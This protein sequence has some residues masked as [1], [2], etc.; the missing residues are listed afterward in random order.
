MNGTLI[1]NTLRGLIYTLRPGNL[2]F[3]LLAAVLLV[4]AGTLYLGDLTAHLL[5][6]EETGT[7]TRILPTPRVW[8]V[9]AAACLLLLAK[10]FDNAA[11]ICAGHKNASFL[12][13][14]ETGAGG[15]LLYL[16]GLL[17]LG[18]ILGAAP[19]ACH[20]LGIGTNITRYVDGTCAII[21]CLLLPAATLVCLEDRSAGAML[22]IRRNLAAIGDI[23]LIRYLI[24]L[25][26]IGGAVA[27]VG[28]AVHHLFRQHLAGQLPAIM[29][30]IAANRYDYTKIPLIHY[31]HAVIIAVL[32]CWLL[33]YI[34]SAAA[35]FF[36]REDDEDDS[37][38]AMNLRE[39]ARLAVADMCP[40]A[41]APT[42][43]NPLPAAPAPGAEP[44]RLRRA[45][46]AHKT[47]PPAQTGGKQEPQLP[48]PD[49]PPPLLRG[50][51]RHTTAAENAP[52]ADKQEPQLPHP[53][54]PPP[55]LRRR[56]TAAVP[57][58][59]GDKNEP[60]IVPPEIELLKEADLTRMNLEEQQAF[61]RALA[62]ADE[63][64]KH[65]RIDDGLALLRPY[66]D[67][68]HDPA[69]YYPAYQRR[70]A[71]Q[72]QDDLLHRLM[73]A[74]ARGN[75]HCYDL[76]RPEL[77]RINPAELPAAIIRPLAQTAAAR[78]QYRT[79]LALTRNFAKNHPEH[80][81]LADNYY[82]AALALA[83]SGRADKALPILQQLLARYPEHPHGDRFRHA[84]AALQDGQTP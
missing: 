36:P 55:L 58:P 62:Q 47:A 39:R 77:D 54:E 17:L 32:G 30:G 10:N 2:F 31:W 7:F 24:L 43:G 37:E 6:Q 22:G 56:Q 44:S 48:R 76:I 38:P 68:A 4:V 65:G 16:I 82:L 26:L 73:M 46:A 75:A 49:E 79:V 78:Q 66:T 84:A 40:A 81:H 64:F 9:L 61:A 33:T 63:H 12:P 13:L 60:H 19:F 80:P 25:L 15:L 29:D 50:N 74:A 70:Y 3:I 21:A 57:A 45:I 5:A 59:D 14:G 11:R 20:N 41:A 53:D 35:W 69:V 42:G 52:A 72:P 83:H 28:C 8:G 71:L 67:D 1:G 34:Y 51:A 27:G 18:L 23:G